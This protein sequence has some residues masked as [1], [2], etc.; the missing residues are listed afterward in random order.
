METTP[1]A[2]RGT[3]LAVLAPYL[4]YGIELHTPRVPGLL[5]GLNGGRFQ[6]PVETC[7]PEGPSESILR[8]LFSY[9]YAEVLPILRPF[10][11]LCDPLPD[12]FIP[13][14]VVASYLTND[15]AARYRLEV[16]P[17]N[18]DCIHV[19]VFEQAG[20]MD[21]EEVQV[22][23]VNLY[24]DWNWDVLRCDEEGECYESCHNPADAIDY[25]RRNHFA[26]N[27]DPIQYIE[28]PAA[29]PASGREGEG[30]RG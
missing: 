9:D 29:T 24:S 25:L 17:G 4:P 12:G 27:L 20:Y 26:V 21:E 11:Q 7:Q 28:K 5:I 14:L 8:G 3:S 13:A 2:T 18:L 19:D 1:N 30:S 6:C 23:V 22:Y 15:W 16:R 10:S